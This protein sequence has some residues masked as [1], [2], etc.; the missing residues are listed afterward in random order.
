MPPPAAAGARM[1]LRP[2]RP[3]RWT[4]FGSRDGDGRANMRRR[5]PRAGH[6]PRS[7]KSATLCTY[8]DT[9]TIQTQYM[10]GRGIGFGAFCPH[11]APSDQSA[12][13]AAE[14][15]CGFEPNLLDPRSEGPALPRG[16][17]QF[18]SH[19]PQKRRPRFRGRGG[20]RMPVAEAT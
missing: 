17:A 6:V 2:R 10:A 13:G 3:D 16:P 18:P 1:P 7:M 5:A 14:Y 20:R 11:L 4:V 15:R 8:S 19:T 12:H 9:V